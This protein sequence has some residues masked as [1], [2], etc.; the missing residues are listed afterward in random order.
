MAH[1]MI[2]VLTEQMRMR[3]LVLER[4]NQIISNLNVM[5]KKI[6]D[7]NETLTKQGVSYAER[8]KQIDITRLEQ[9]SVFRKRISLG[10]LSE[11]QCDV[12]CRNNRNIPFWEK[13]TE[14]EIRTYF[15]HYYTYD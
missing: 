3:E 13:W 2:Q 1:E 10:R 9:I 11:I 5:E 12:W 8:S 15:E 4:R 14:V 6:T 7:L